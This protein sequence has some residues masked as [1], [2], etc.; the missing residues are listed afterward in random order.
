MLARTFGLDRTLRL[1]LLRYRTFIWRAWAKGWSRRR[2]DR[3]G[4]SRLPRLALYVD[5][6]TNATDPLT[7]EAAVAVLKHQGADVI[8]VPRSRPTGLAALSAGDADTA[9]DHARR[10]VRLLADFAR[11]GYTIVCVDPSAA[12]AITQD[13]PALID[14][15]D[16]ALVAESTVELMT[17]LG[18]WHE[19][20]LLKTDFREQDL[21]LGH[22]IPCHVKALKRTIAAPCLLGLIPGVHV[23]T[24]DKGCS[25]MAG[26]WGTL[27][28][29]RSA[30]Q[31]IGQR[32]TE[33]LNGPDVIFGSSECG[34]CR[35]QMQETTGK[36]AV[37]PVQYLAMAYGLLP[38]V[39]R[40]LVV[41]LRDRVSR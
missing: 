16:V 41:P 9:K 25:G 24:I 30:S 13:Y 40:R 10:T 12:V 31:T 28:R 20:G 39:G 38:E 36:R 18:Q 5:P 21:W 33:A 3:S 2:K 7:G 19:T 14:S 26:P 15:P 32:M 22:H 29:N 4:D 11:D 37:H 27:A 1:P 23:Q 17:L 35:I 34:S 6:L 8:V